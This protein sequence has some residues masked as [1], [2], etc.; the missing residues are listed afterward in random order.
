MFVAKTQFL[1]LYFEKRSAVYPF[2]RLIILMKHVQQKVTWR[3]IQI[4]YKIWP[5]LGE[6]F[7]T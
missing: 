4:I 2:L 7:C 6:S 3:Q 1:C 5:G